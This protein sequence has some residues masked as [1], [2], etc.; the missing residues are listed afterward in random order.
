MLRTK[1]MEENILEILKEEN[2]NAFQSKKL[3]AKKII[4]IIQNF[5]GW[6]DVNTKVLGGRWYK[7]KNKN[8][9]LDDLFK[10]W[11]EI[12]NQINV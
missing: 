4:F 6:K 7:Y 3:T 10:C 5:I 8:Y 1:I 2:Y 9:S 11:L 12:Q